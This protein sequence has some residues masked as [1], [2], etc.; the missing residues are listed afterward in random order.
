MLYNLI[1]IKKLITL[2]YKKQVLKVEYNNYFLVLK[3]NRK[4]VILTKPSIGEEIKNK[5]LTQYLFL[6]IKFT[7]FS[8]N[9][10]KCKPD[11]ESKY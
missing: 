2:F 8:K 11:K 10:T 5:I 7:N 3:I 6:W 1:F 4:N 9:N